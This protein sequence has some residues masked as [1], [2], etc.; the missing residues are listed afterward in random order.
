MAVFGPNTLLILGGSKSFGTHISEN[1]RGDSFALF[2]GGW[3][4]D[5]AIIYD[6]LLQIQ[7]WI[8]M[9]VDTTQFKGYTLLST[10]E[11]DNSE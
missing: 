9:I 5:Y 4:C 10:D 1:H 3:V 2:F 7:G 8:L 6:A 11:E